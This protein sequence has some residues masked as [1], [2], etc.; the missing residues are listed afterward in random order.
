MFNVRGRVVLRV[1]M[2]VVVCT[3]RVMRLWY[4]RYLL[5]RCLHGDVL[6]VAR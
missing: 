4:V 5:V 6:C 2:C 1:L 3:V